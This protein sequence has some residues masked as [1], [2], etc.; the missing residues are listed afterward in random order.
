VVVQAPALQVESVSVPAEQVVAAQP[1][2]SVAA[3]VQAPLP[4][5]L[6]AQA[7]S[8]PV[9]CLR[10][11]CPE[12]T[13]LHAPGVPA[14][15]QLLQVALHAFSQQTFS[16]QNPLSHS[17][18]LLHLPPAGACRRHPCRAPSGPAR[19]AEVARAVREAGLGAAPVG[20]GAG[21]QVRVVLLQ[22]FPGAQGVFES[23]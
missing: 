21:S 5:Q 10:G 23:Q 19:A 15:A 12:G 8:L 1:L 7:A 4:S 2:V 14:S 13:S 17:S 6:P 9:H 22:T 11:S 3:N 16:T 18:A 20:L